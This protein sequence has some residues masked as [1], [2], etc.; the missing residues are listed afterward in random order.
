MKSHFFV[1]ISLSVVLA[2]RRSMMF[3]I[4]TRPQALELKQPESGDDSGV[5]PVSFDSE[6]S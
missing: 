1:A 5:S 3:I 6:Q 2:P 4:M